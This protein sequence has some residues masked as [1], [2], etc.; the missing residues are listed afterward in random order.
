M[1]ATTC[2][3]YK[4]QVDDIHFLGASPANIL[5]NFSQAKQ[6]ALLIPDMIKQ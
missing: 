3:N 6:S 1:I 4:E 2:Y 5:V